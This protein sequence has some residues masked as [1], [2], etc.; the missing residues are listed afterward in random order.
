MNAGQVGGAL[1]VVVS[2]VVSFALLPQSDFVI[3]GAVKFVL[4]CINVGVTALALYLNVRM[5]GAA[6]P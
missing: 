6:K 3:P 5:P 1:L 2:A 4:G